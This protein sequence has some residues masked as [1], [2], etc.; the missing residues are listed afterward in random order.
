MLRA[1]PAKTNVQRSGPRTIQ[2]SFLRS[3]KPLLRHLPVHHSFNITMSPNQPRTSNH[4]VT[5]QAEKKW[6]L[7]FS[8]PYENPQTS[9]NSVIPSDEFSLHH[10]NID[11]AI[12]LIA[13]YNP[14][15][16]HKIAD[17]LFRFLEIQNI[18]SGSRLQSN[19][20]LFL[21][22]SFI[23]Y[24]HH[25]NSIQPGTIN[26]YLSGIY[27]FFKLIYGQ[28][29][30]NISNPQISLFIKGLQKKTVPLSKTPDFKHPHS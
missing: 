20:L 7:I 28:Q 11:Q 17:A 2:P 1:S 3:L 24:L 30:F 9:V 15:H 25:I 6:S 21:M 12:I 5:S 8:T 18:S 14:G 13:E 29:C 16:Q 23:S 27:F 19:S 26:V 4:P 10:H 22:S